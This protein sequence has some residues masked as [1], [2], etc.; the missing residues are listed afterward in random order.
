MAFVCVSGERVY[1][2]EV[3]LVKEVEKTFQ[4]VT[5]EQIT[6]AAWMS[7]KVHQTVVCA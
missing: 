3:W 5:G 1:M 2:C 7:L 4:E 6:T